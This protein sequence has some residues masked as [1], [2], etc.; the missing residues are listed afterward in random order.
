M[1]AVRRLKRTATIISRAVELARVFPVT[2]Q[3]KRHPNAT[4]ALHYLPLLS[5]TDKT[6]GT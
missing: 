3:R 4:E 1:V 6:L 5:L 2:H